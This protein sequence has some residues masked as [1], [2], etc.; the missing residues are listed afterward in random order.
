MPS[1]GLRLT[2]VQLQPIQKRTR[3]CVLVFGRERQLGK[4][5]AVCFWTQL[6]PA[7]AF[8]LLCCFNLAHVGCLCH[9]TAWTAAFKQPLLQ[10]PAHDPVTARAS[11]AQEA[12]QGR[13][14]KGS[15]RKAPKGW[16][17]EGRAP[18]PGGCNDQ[19]QGEAQ[20]RKATVGRM[21]RKRAGGCICRQPHA[22][23]ARFCRAG[24]AALGCRQAATVTMWYAGLSSAQSLC[25]REASPA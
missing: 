11:G 1:H 15:T 14:P 17:K 3:V 20:E 24:S 4:S 18:P 25:V 13:P 22:S 16:H 7:F 2:V 19:Q 10:A 12:A 23:R 6:C 5:S 8:I 21:K 9:A